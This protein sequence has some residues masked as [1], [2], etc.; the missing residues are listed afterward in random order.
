MADQGP[1]HYCGDTVD[2][3]M[4]GGGNPPRREPA[5]Y[6]QVH[7]CTRPNHRLGGSVCY[8]HRSCHE[9]APR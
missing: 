8:A 1:C 6:V 9:E 4:A 2:A 3:I 7:D 5:N